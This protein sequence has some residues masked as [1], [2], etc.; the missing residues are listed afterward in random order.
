MRWV[1]PQFSLSRLVGRVMG[2]HLLSSLLM[3]QTR[4]LRLP[5]GLMDELHGTVAAWGVD[6][7]APAWVNALEDRFTTRGAWHATRA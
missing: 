6:R 7:Q 4:P 2:Y 1:L 5:A 3:D